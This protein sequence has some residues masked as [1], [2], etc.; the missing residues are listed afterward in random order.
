[1]V[2]RIKAWSFAHG[3]IRTTN[4]F[5][6]SYKRYFEFN[7]WKSEFKLPTFW[8][9]IYVSTKWDRFRLTQL[10]QAWPVYQHPRD[11]INRNKLQIH[12]KRQKNSFLEQFP[13][14]S[15][16]TQKDNHKRM[17]KMRN[18]IQTDI[19]DYNLWIPKGRVVHLF[20]TCKCAWERA[21]TL[22]LSQRQLKSD[23]WVT[24]KDFL[25]I[26]VCLFSKSKLK[27]HRNSLT[28]GPWGP[29]KPLLTDFQSLRW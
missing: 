28:L 5:N 6:N 2:Y 25:H 27:H 8:S 12:L 7:L 9:R 24:P 13:N 11:Q 26:F 4:N 21:I 29:K 14:S 16:L 20:P 1:M 10:P 17:R 19:D 15:R 22:F 18:W 3:I 23:Y